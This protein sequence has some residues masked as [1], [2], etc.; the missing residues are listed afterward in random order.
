MM[1]T[2]PYVLG[3]LSLLCLSA[4]AEQRHGEQQHLERGR[5]PQWEFDARF[6]HNHYYPAR[7]YV[8]PRLPAGSISVGFGRDAFYFQSGVWFRSSGPRFVVVEP[9]IGI[10][11]PVLPA[12][13][14]LVQAGAQT[15]CYANGVYYAPSPGG[16]AVVGAPSLP[17]GVAAAQPMAPASPGVPMP[18]PVSTPVAAP[19]PMAQALQQMV[20]YPR[21]G[22]S[23]ATAEADRLECNRWAATQPQ[24]IDPGVFSRAIA[25]CLDGRG[26]TVR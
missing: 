2:H 4:Q 18:A 25:A 23:S 7:G 26:Y 17:G 8:M 19:V 11:L 10:V 16:Y 12:G 14:A 1:T 5:G 6:Q 21:N 20:I 9:P 3:L 24:A 15:Y 13:C 22:Q